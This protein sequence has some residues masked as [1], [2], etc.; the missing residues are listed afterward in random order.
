MPGI[1]G[2]FWGGGRNLEQCKLAGMHEFVILTRTPSDEE[3]GV[4]A[5]HLCGQASFSLVGPGHI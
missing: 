5:G 1:G 4:P 3:Y 2:H